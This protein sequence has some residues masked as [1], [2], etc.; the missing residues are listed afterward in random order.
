MKG[1]AGRLDIQATFDYFS[2]LVEVDKEEME[3]HSH[4]EKMMWI[5]RHAHLNGFEKALRNYNDVVKE[6]VR[7]ENG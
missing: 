2:N 4:L 6:A 3:G 1:E 7:N 5:V